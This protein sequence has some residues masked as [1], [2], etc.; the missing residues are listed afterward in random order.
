[1]VLLIEENDTFRSNQIRQGII[2]REEALRKVQEENRPRFE[3]IKWYCETVGIDF[4][5]T[6]KA[7]NQIPKLYP[8]RPSIMI[9]VPSRFL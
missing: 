3:S 2:T 1:M 8:T 4:R 6:I 9:P 7:V 5:E